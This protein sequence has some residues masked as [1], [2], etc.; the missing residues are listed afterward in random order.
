MS[1][2]DQIKAVEA[3]RTKLMIGGD[4]DALASI[5]SDRLV[6]ISTTGTVRS[7][8]E[9]I[10]L[11]RQGDAEFLKFSVDSM[12]IRQFHDHVI[13]TGHYTN[14][15]KYHGAVLPIKHGV[16]TRVYEK[17]RGQWILLSHQAT[18]TNH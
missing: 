1:V 11:V 3:L 8:E 4:A 15:E 14:L 7:K 16:F 10:D 12:V 9:Y 6:H 13:V 2:A 5:M 17:R 18:K